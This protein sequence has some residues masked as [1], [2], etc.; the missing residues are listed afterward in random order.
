MMTELVVGRFGVDRVGG[1]MIYWCP[2][3]RRVILCWSS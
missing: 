3:G 2:V 1:G